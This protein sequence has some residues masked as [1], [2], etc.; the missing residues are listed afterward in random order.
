MF[1]WFENRLD[2]FPAAEPVEPVQHQPYRVAVVHP[3][4][5][6]PRAG[7]RPAHRAELLVVLPRQVV[8]HD[9]ADPLVA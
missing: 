1:R 2:P 5:G 6:R 9:L 7:Q 4:H 8:E 3:H